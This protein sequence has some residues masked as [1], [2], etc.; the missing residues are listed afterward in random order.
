M[1]PVFQVSSLRPYHQSEHTVTPPPPLEVDAEGVS[2]YEVEEVLAHKPIKQNRQ[3]TWQFLIKCK[4]Y[5]HE[6]ISWEPYSN[7]ANP[8]ITLQPFWDSLGGI[9]VHPQNGRKC[10][11]P[12]AIVRPKAK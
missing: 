4:G 8:E 2:I 5:G 11:A 3:N 9:P 1:H 12:Q 6:H 7:I 10:K